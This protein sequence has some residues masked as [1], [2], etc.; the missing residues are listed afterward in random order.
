MRQL[1]AVKAVLF[2]LGLFLAFQAAAWAQ[3]SSVAEVLF[4]AGKKYYERG[5]YQQALHEF[6]KA[7]L[8][9]PEHA[10]SLAYI[11]II[12]KELGLEP[13]E[14][15]E[16]TDYFEFDQARE[17]EEVYIPEEEIA[18]EQA[19]AEALEQAEEKIATREEEV[20]IEVEEEVEEVFDNFLEDM[21]QKIAPA[22]ISGEYTVGLG[23]RENEIIWK[24]ANGDYNE[25]NWRR[26]DA[27]FGINTYDT[28]VY[29]RLRLNIDTEKE[30]GFNLHTNITIDPWSFIGK[31]DEVTLTASNGE[32]ALV[33]LKYWSNTRS[34][35]NE[36]VGSAS[37]VFSLP[38]VKVSDDKTKAFTAKGIEYDSGYETLEVPGLEID[39]ELWPLRELWFDYNNEEK[40]NLRFFPVAYQNQALTSDDP[41]G[42]SNHMIYWEES[43]WL[44]RW[45]PGRINTEISP[46]DFTR[47]EWEDDLSFF[48]RDSSMTRL[49]SLRGFSMQTQPLE[50]VSIASTVA[51]PKGLW[52]DYDQFDNIEGASRIKF[53]PNDNLELGLVNT[54]RYGLEEGDKDAENR[55]IGADI[56]YNFTPELSVK[57][58]LAYS[59]DER[60]L[61]QEPYDTKMSGNAYVV[62]LKRGKL[63]E[64]R[65]EQW[66]EEELEQAGLQEEDSLEETEPFDWAM[67]LSWTHMDKGFLPALANYRLTRKDPFWGRHIQF[68]QPF[69]YYYGGLYYP[70]LTWYDIRPYRIGDSVDINRD[71]FGLRLEKAFLE[72][73]METLLDSRTACAASGG[74]YIESINRLESEWQANEKLQ[75]KFLGIYHNLPDT[76]AGYDPLIYDVDTNKYLVNSSIEAGKDPSLKTVSTGFKYDFWDWLSFDFVYEYTNDFTIGLDDYPRRILDNPGFST[77]TEDGLNWRESEPFLYDQGY[78]PQPPYPW[79]SIYKAGFGFEPNDKL[80]LRLEFT[81]NDYKFASQ[82]DDNINHWGLSA[83]YD[84]TE[85]L[86]L[87]FNYTL[88]RTYNLQGR[89][90]GLDYGRH[91]NVF[92]NF[93]YKMDDKGVFSLQFG[94]GAVLPYSTMFTTS[95]YP[96]F[97]PTL[98][99]AHIVRAYFSRKF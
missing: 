59:R 44:D 76:I 28:R 41:L 18:R 50:N 69:A 89:G 78:F 94:E 13:T 7:L 77:F 43:P 6:E 5:D 90:Q 56:S 38:E 58:E 82:I 32:S 85:K 93:D 95:P 73:A 16:E 9:D 40:L 29:D 46:E 37:N 65:P 62:E 34:T 10:R 92:I 74:G 81:K 71:V 48:T 31:S 30:Q 57:G 36:S 21:N 64:E 42:L 45:Q 23:G 72:G 87:G 8:A 51:S 98:D 96:G 26:R 70:S 35:I 52:Q 14:I 66:Y 88:A 68:K 55:V 19:L 1:S 97:L 79:F 12:E 47:G 33:Q 80:K 99:T 67:R 2:C 75:I 84:L 53:T 61:T 63:K 83:D 49:T 11:Q 20:K 39:R 60:D 15:E 91:H 27:D 3:H 17:P 25:A 54:F 24:A 86:S 4:D 22:K